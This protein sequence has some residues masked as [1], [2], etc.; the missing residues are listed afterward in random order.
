[1]EYICQNCGNIFY[2]V[3]A[4]VTTEAN[5][6]PVGVEWLTRTSCP[7]CS[8]DE[9]VEACHFRKCGGAYLETDLIAGY[10]C[11]ECL[12]EAITPR[13]LKL[14]IQDPLVQDVFAEWLRLHEKEER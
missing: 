12:K 4:L 13:N 8:S 1:M 3:E 2:D 14:F 7:C 9:I 6:T 10:Y 5:P 11:K